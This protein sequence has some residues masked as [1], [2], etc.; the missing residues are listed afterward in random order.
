MGDDAKDPTAASERD[1]SIRLRPKGAE[2]L[3]T[4]QSKA[5]ST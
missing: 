2:G 1:G 4:S 5:L 3:G